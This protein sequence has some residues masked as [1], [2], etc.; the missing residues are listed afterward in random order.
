[1]T[2]APNAFKQTELDRSGGQEKTMMKIAR[3]LVD[4]SVAEHLLE[5][6]TCVVCENGKKVLCVEVL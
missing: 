5:H 6:G 1:M 2:D 4:S 3:V